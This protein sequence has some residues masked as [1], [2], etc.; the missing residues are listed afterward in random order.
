MLVIIATI[1]YSTKHWQHETLANQ[2]N[3]TLAKKTLANNQLVRSRD[4]AEMLAA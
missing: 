2:Q 3:I 4:Q 1:P